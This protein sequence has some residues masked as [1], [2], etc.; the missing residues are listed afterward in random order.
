MESK[1]AYHCD[2]TSRLAV[3]IE[4]FKQPSTLPTLL[5]DF[6]SQYCFKLPEE[7]KCHSRKSCSRGFS[8]ASDLLRALKKI[9]EKDTAW[10]RNSV[11]DRKRGIPVRLYKRCLRLERGAD[12]MAQLTRL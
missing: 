7:K 6:V 9:E 3:Q 4:S 11:N 8:K 12:I 2:C 10:V 1:T 5:M